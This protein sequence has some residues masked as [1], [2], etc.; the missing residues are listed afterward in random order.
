MVMKNSLTI[1]LVLVTVSVLGLTVASQS[2]VFAQGEEQ[3][4][5]AQRGNDDPIQD[6]QLSPDQRQQIRAIRVQLQEERRAVNLRLR[7]AN[8]ALQDALDNDSLDEA[9]IEQHLQEL[10][11]AQAAQVRMRVMTEVRIRRVLTKEQRALLKEIRHAGRRSI[12]DRQRRRDA[13]N[14]RRRRNQGNTLAPPNLP[15]RARP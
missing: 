10:A 11:I 3:R 14:N 7:A 1:R 6:L 8:Q 15:P 5:Q 2:Y 13:L 12:E 9:Q 4:E